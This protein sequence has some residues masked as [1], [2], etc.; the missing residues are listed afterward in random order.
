MLAKNF[1][2]HSLSDLDA[3]VASSVLPLRWLPARFAAAGGG[4]F[5]P[6]DCSGNLSGI[7]PA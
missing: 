1:P 3:G 5:L 2:F 7:A 4:E 6:D